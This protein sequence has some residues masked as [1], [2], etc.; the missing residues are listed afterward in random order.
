M[1][2]KFK[3]KNTGDC[4]PF[5]KKVINGRDFEAGRRLRARS[6][7]NVCEQPEIKPDAKITP[8]EYFLRLGCGYEFVTIILG[9]IHHLHDLIPLDS[10]VGVE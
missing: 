5:V 8:L 1:N 6:I 4:S 2:S 3:I 10:L 7:L 9:Y